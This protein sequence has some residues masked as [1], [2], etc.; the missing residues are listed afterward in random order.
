M[1]NQRKTKRAKVD[2]YLNKIMDEALHLARTS[3]ISTEGI[4]LSKVLEPQ[5]AGKRVGLEFQLP[6]NDEVIWA[7]GQVVREGARPTSS[8]APVEGSAIQFTAVADRFRRMIEA[9]VSRVAG[10]A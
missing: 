6:G 8:G 2:V 9:Y 7:A 5:H 4:W 10:N 1:A 3:D